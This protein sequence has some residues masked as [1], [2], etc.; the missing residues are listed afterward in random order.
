MQSLDLRCNAL[1]DAGAAELASGIS[2]NDSLQQ[3]NIR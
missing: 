3:L 2:T 1:G